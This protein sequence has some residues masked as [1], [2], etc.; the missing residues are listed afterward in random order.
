[1]P[2]VAILFANFDEKNDG[3]PHTMT[4]DNV[5]VFF[6]E[7]GHIMHHMC[8]E[9]NNTRFSGTNVEKDFIE[10]PSSML[11]HWMEDYNIIIKM[12]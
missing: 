12:S 10:M 11:E 2:P 1:M 7:F 9:A 4:Y 6:H 3:K 5:V 8:N